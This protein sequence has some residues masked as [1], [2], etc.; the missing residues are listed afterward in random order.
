MWGLP[1]V[2]ARLPRV[3]QRNTQTNS[4]DN[5]SSDPPVVSESQVKNFEVH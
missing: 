4:P 5:I 3:L 2:L 1:D